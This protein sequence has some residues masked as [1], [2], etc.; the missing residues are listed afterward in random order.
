MGNSENLRK[1]EKLDDQEMKDIK[2]LMLSSDKEKV[3]ITCP[4]GYHKAGCEYILGYSVFYNEKGQAEGVQCD[5]GL[6]GRP[7]FQYSFCPYTEGSGSGSG[8]EGS[9]QP[10]DNKPWYL[11]YLQSPGSGGSSGYVS[12]PCGIGVDPAIVYF[13]W[14]G[15]G[16]GF[17]PFDAIFTM[18]SHG[19]KACADPAAIKY[20]L[21]SK[22]TIKTPEI[23]DLIVKGNVNSTNLIQFG[24]ALDIFF[25]GYVVAGSGSGSGSGG[26]L[27]IGV[28]NYTNT[29][30]IIV[31]RCDGYIYY[32]DATGSYLKT[33]I[34]GNLIF[35]YKINELNLNNVQIDYNQV[36]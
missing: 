36:W 12:T 2:P 3:T 35:E 15:S 23:Y 19:L 28:L 34:N 22:S 14:Y 32:F 5:I 17:R 10:W 1:I 27:S 9:G 11:P 6:P 30:I 7:W 24:Q 4:D 8:S 13:E 20:F 29:P 31:S 33:T 21:L 26:T 16:S 18:A 25:N